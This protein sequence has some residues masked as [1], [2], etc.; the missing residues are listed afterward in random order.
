MI[1]EKCGEQNDL[2]NIKCKN[3]GKSLDFEKGYWKGYEKGLKVGDQLAKNSDER[4]EDSE[5][6]E[7]TSDALKIVS[8][9]TG[10]LITMLMVLGDPIQL[11][12][13]VFD[14]STHLSFIF[15][16]G[17]FLLVGVVNGFL[18]SVCAIMIGVHTNRIYRWPWPMKYIISIIAALLV[19]WLIHIK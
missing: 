7:A 15:I 17:L 4:K 16:I 2:E 19:F 12:G 6:S 13:L 11:L 8:F 9:F 3:C 14:N 5:D 1:C 10:L 18:V